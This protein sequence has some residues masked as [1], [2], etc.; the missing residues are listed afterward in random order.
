MF[1][2]VQGPRVE[3]K[4]C[5]SMALMSREFSQNRLLTR[6]EIYSVLW[7][8]TVWPK[9][10]ATYMHDVD[11]CCNN[12]QL[13]ELSTNFCFIENVE[14]K[15]KRKKKSADWKVYMLLKQKKNV[16][17]IVLKRISNDWKDIFLRI[18]TFMSHDAKEYSVLPVTCMHRVVSLSSID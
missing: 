9:Q 8:R 13:V 4:G 2:R 16:L 14:R 5:C 10:D 3:C 6:N 1:W 17:M 7:S 15:L 18:F 12:I 11:R